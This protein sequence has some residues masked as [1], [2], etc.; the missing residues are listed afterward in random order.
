MTLGETN[1]R[2]LHADQEHTG[3]RTAVFALLFLSL[4]VAFLGLRALLRAV[5]TDWIVDYAFALSC[6]GAFPVAVGIIWVAERYMKQVWPSGRTVTLIS[7]G[8]TVQTEAGN[9]VTLTQEQGVVPLA[10]HFDLQ[11]WQRGGRERRVPQ[12]WTCLAVELKASKEQIIVFTYLPPDQADQWLGQKTPFAFHQIHP[13]RI[14]DSSWR[15]RLAGPRRPEIPA[16]IITGKDGPYWLAER[17]R[18]IDGFE[19]PP[20]EFET[21]MNHIQTTL[22]L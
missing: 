4:I 20:E 16:E 8:V 9:Q 13:Q 15:K 1:P 3:L 22:E 12:N 18:W 11:G 14:Y 6:F 10:W 17:R 19:L 21:F 5:G 2:I 7:N